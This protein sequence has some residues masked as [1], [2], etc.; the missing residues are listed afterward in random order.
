VKL[1]RPLA[2]LASNS[3][4][5]AY[6]RITAAMTAATPRTTAATVPSMRP[7]VLMPVMISRPPG[8]RER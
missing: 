3:T 4:K 8:A 1:T 6:T 2:G 7:T 5:I